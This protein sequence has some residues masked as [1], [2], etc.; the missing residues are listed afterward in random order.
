AARA[1]MPQVIDLR[2]FS[3]VKF[4]LFYQPRFL[5][6]RVVVNVTGPAGAGVALARPV[7]VGATKS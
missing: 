2:R 6:W 5:T 3:E 7:L 1:W 4:S